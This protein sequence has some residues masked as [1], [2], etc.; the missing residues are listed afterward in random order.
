MQKVTL[1]SGTIF[2]MH[3]KLRFLTSFEM[4]INELYEKGSVGLRFR[5][6][7]KLL[8]SK[9]LNSYHSERS[10]ESRIFNRKP[11]EKLLIC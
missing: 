8:S 6:K 10:E 3:V 4:T 2:L 7:L 1:L 5:R 9:H 11:R